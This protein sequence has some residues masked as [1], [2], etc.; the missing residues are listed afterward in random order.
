MPSARDLRTKVSFQRRAVNARGQRLGD[1]AEEFTHL[2][3]VTFTS[4]RSGG[5]VALQGRLQNVVPVSM[6][7]RDDAYTRQ[8]DSSWRAVIASGHLAGTYNIRSRAPTARPGWITLTCDTDDN[9]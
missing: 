3:G 8:I 5:E 7:V 4:L 1:F 6:I 9:D 2:A